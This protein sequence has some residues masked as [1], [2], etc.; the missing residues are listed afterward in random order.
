MVLGVLV[1]GVFYE[2]NILLGNV[3][4]GVIIIKDFII[5]L[6]NELEC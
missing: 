1:V 6:L 2:L 3:L 4:M 5:Y